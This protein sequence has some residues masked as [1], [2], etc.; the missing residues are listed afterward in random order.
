MEIDRAVQ[1]H[2]E[3]EGE[4]EAERNKERGRQKRV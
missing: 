4:G 2:G 1:T 3:L